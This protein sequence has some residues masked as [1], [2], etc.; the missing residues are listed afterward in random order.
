MN[1]DSIPHPGLFFIEDINSLRNH[2]NKFVE[3]LQ[4]YINVVK[5]LNISHQ[6]TEI[7]ENALIEEL[8]WAQQYEKFLSQLELYFIQSQLFE[9]IQKNGKCVLTSNLE[10][11]DSIPELVFFDKEILKET[12]KLITFSKKKKNNYFISN[13]NINYNFSYKGKRL[14][15]KSIQPNKL[16]E[17]IESYE[18]WFPRDR[19]EFENKFKVCIKMYMKKH[20]TKKIDTYAY[21]FSN[22]FKKSFLN[23]YN[24]FKNRIVERIGRRLSKTEKEAIKDPLLQEEDIAE[25]GIRRMRVWE[26][27]KSLRINFN[28]IDKNKNNILFKSFDTQHDKSL[29][30]R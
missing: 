18:S 5:D 20:R 21:A 28:Y 23:S 14:N 17:K 4:N 25:L 2:K 16:Y 22:E 26:K 11:S 27:P 29:K 12:K 3:N 1:F 10:P 15:I 13:E 19:S 9:L 24:L 7:L 6:T 8:P 30:K